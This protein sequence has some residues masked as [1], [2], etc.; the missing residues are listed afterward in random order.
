MKIKVRR[1]RNGKRIEKHPITTKPPRT[2]KES[3]YNVMDRKAP[4][5]Q[6][7]SN[8]DKQGAASTVESNR[9]MEVVIDAVKR[10]NRSMDTD[11][12]NTDIAYSRCS[13][14]DKNI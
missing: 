7:S 10:H 2:R 14:M 13:I 12:I 8:S 11:A 1:A 5:N 3:R 9:D 4:I 6:V